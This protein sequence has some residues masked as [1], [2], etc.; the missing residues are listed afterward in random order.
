[1]KG[2]KR[3]ILHDKQ[4]NRLSLSGP[5]GAEGKLPEGSTG[6]Y[7]A[8]FGNGPLRFLSHTREARAPCSIQKDIRERNKKKTSNLLQ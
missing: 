4:S 3:N 2:K 5:P 1:M 7:A 8:H 6:V